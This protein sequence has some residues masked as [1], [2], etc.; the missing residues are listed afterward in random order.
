M[1]RVVN[2]YVC[3]IAGMEI[4]LVSRVDQ[5]VLRWFKHMQIMGEYH[6]V[7][8]MSMPEVSGWWV[9]G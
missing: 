6:M 2:V 3:R 7:R 4:E 8:R 9:Q 1:D 5:R